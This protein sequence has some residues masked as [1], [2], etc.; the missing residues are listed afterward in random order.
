MALRSIADIGDSPRLLLLS[1]EMKLPGAELAVV[2]IDK[3]RN[4]CLNPAHPRGHHKAR[5]F[6]SALRILQSDAEWLRVRL[7]D[8]ALVGDVNEAEADE[9]GRLMSWTSNALKKIDVRSSIA[10]GSSNAAKTSL[11]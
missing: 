11:G 8:A 3:L 4:Y 7:L 5:V 10:P 2:D 9:Y 6:A 1:F